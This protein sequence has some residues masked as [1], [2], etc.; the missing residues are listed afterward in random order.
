MKALK[1]SLCFFIVFLFASCSGSE[2]H[3]LSSFISA[4]NKASSEEIS[5]S[6]FIFSSVETDT[7]TAFLGD[8]KNSVLLSLKEN[9]TQKIENCSVIL[10]KSPGTLPSESQIA[11]FRKVLISTLAAYCTLSHDSANEIISAF[12][13]DVDETFMKSGELTLKRENYYF[14]YYSDEITN[15]VVISNTYLKKPEETSKPV[16]RPYYGEDFAEKTE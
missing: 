5:F 3:N 12:G 13:L 11:Q 6:D 8:N 10:T 4:Y 9:S 14:V 7:Y 1:I 16:S 2:F 15:R